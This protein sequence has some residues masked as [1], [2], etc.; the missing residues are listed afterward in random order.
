LPISTR[1]VSPTEIPR[2]L[3][4]AAA[5]APVSP[6]SDPTCGCAWVKA[7]GSMRTMLLISVKAISPFPVVTAADRVA[8]VDDEATPGVF[9]TR[10][11]S[12]PVD[13]EGSVDSTTTSPTVRARL[14]AAPAAEKDSSAADC[15]TRIPTRI[16]R[17]AAVEALLRMLS[18]R[19]ACASNVNTALRPTGRIR[20][21]RGTRSGVAAVRAIAA[22]IETFIAMAWPPEAPPVGDN[23]SRAAAPAPKI[24]AVIQ[25]PR[26]MTAVATSPSRSAAR[27][28]ID[29]ARRAARRTP[30]TDRPSPT[31]TDAPRIHHC[32]TPVNP[33]GTKPRRVSS[34][35]CTAIRPMPRGTPVTVPTPPSSTASPTSNRRTWRRSAPTRRNRASSR[36]RWSTVKAKVVPMMKKAKNAAKASVTASTVTAT[37]VDAACAVTSIGLAPAA[38]RDVAADSNSRSEDWTR[39]TPRATDSAAPMNSVQRSARVARLTRNMS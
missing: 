14:S 32:H 12:S 4:P 39:A 35:A 23:A 36:A 27:G 31:S 26:V 3:G 17:G 19:F 13:D 8:S 29:A 30:L 15:P 37:V 20:A 34:S 2:A 11:S 38:G 22:A 16:T 10:W 25:R 21:T 24:P 18:R 33:A 1:T 5:V 28:A 6:D 9:A 7:A